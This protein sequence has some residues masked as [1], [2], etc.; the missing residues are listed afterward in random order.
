MS[1]R[2]VRLILGG[3]LQSHSEM[4]AHRREGG[5]TFDGDSGRR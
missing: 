2:V 3:D 1:L 5:R 4:P